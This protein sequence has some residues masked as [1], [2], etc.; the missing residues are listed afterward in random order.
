[1]PVFGAVVNAIN[2]YWSWSVKLFTI[3]PSY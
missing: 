1:M 2:N 3:A